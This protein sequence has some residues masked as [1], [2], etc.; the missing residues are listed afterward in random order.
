MN[1]RGTETQREAEIQRDQKNL[2]AS[3]PLR[4][5]PLSS[6][7]EEQPQ[8]HR[9]TEIGNVDFFVF[10]CAS[11]SLRLIPLGPDHSLDAIFEDGNVEVDEQPPLNPGKFEVGQELGF[12][13]RRES[14]NGLELNHQGS[15][16]QDVEP[17]AALQ[18][19]VFVANGQR[20][21]TH[22]RNPGMP[23]F[24]GQ[25]FLVGG[26]QQAGSQ[27]PVHLN[28]KSNDLMR[29]RVFGFHGRK[30]TTEALRHRGNF[31]SFSKNSALPRLCG[32]KSYLRM[33]KNNHRGTET[34]RLGMSISASSSAPLRLCGSNSL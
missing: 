3:A 21:L 16:K 34:Q 5:Q 13:D 8:R 1:H 11:A 26:L 32:S 24:I 33:K 12:V 14:F 7:E 18:M 27:L 4:F 17:V 30:I 29:E 22:M 6:D 28:G 23:Q 9:D 20:M 19:N 2:C 10:L 31:Q 15:W 25:T